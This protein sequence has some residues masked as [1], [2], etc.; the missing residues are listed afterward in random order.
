MGEA[1]NALTG[2]VTGPLQRVFRKTND[3]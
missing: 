1:V 2:K 3:G